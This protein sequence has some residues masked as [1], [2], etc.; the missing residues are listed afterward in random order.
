V[1]G[2]EGAFPAGEE[3]TRGE[4]ELTAQAQHSEPNALRSHKSLATRG[5]DELTAQAQHCAVISH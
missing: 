1:G 5:E 3:A 4:H 2:G